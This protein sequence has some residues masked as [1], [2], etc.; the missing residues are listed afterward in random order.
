MSR[1]KIGHLPIFQVDRRILRSQVDVPIV[2]G[3]IPSG[4]LT[5]IFE[6]LRD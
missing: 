2:M 6:S 1:A 5:R 3:K 4:D